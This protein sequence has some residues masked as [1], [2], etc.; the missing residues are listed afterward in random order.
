MR[1]G[2]IISAAIAALL[3][4]AAIP[5]RATDTHDYAKDEYGIIGDGLSP[6]KKMSLAAHGDGEGGSDNFHVW[7]MAEPA[8]RKLTPLDDIGSDNNLD[9]GPDAYHAIWAADSRHVAV[10]FRSDRHVL[11]MN[12]YSVEDR[13]TKLVSGP[14]LFRDVTSREV[15][16]DDPAR[17]SVTVID[18]TGTKTFRLTEHR[19]FVTTDAA[20]ARI[21]G[22]YGKVGE[23]LDDGRLVIEFAAEA[24]CVLMPGHRY[25]IVDLRVG[26]FDQ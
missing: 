18:W 23:K 25:R 7:L 16:R 17:Q 26:K 1:H 15:S 8:H 20:F 6:D 2:R 3:A 5:A 21:F 22:A 13:R 4:F 19:T 24:D 14:T 12:L 9:T 10:N 11:E